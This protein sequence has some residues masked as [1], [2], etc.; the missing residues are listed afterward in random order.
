MLY[1]FII[2]FAHKGAKRIARQLRGGMAASVGSCLL[3]LL[4][5][6][7]DIAEFHERKTKAALCHP[8]R[9]WTATTSL[10]IA[11]AKVSRRDRALG[12]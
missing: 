11:N 1:Y 7:G 3:A 10:N 5:A 4:F 12:F 2:S 6:I 8:Q 9:R